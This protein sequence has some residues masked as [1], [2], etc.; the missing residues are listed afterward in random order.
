M[1]TCQINISQPHAC[2]RKMH[3]ALIR[4]GR[5]MAQMEKLQMPPKTSDRPHSPVRKVRAFRENEVPQFG[6][7]DDDASHGVVGDVQGHEVQLA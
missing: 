6:R 4:D 5:G 7:V 1:R 3:D 2:P